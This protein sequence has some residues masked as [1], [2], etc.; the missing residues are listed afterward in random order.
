MTSKGSPIGPTIA[1]VS[2]SFYEVEWL[3]Q[4]PKEFISVFT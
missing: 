4:C 3:E 1:N 2:L